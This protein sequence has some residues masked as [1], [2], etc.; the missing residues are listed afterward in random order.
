ML[1]YVIIF[2]NTNTNML[3]V[4]EEARYVVQ[5]GQGLQMP[6][7]LCEHYWELGRSH[8]LEPPLG[9]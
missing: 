3:K 6:G 8:C 1:A 2:T 5:S 4:Q 9:L 7:A